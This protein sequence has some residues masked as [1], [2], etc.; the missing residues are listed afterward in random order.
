MPMPA[1][2]Y[3]DYIRVYEWNG[4]GEVHLGP[5]VAQAGSFGIYTDE[6]STNGGLEA[7]VTS[8]IYVWE[9]TLTAGSI[10]PYEGNN[11]LSWRTAGRGWFGA[12]VMSIQPLNLFDFGAG[13]L[14]F[15]IKIP[16]NV[17][18]KIGI[19]DAWGNQ[20]YIPFPAHQTT[21]GL[22]RDGEWGQGSIPV[23]DIRGTAMDLRMLS[24]PFVILEEQ[25]TPCEFA[26]DDIYWDA[27]PATGVGNGELA[28]GRRVELHPNVPNPFT[29][30]TEIRF[31][32]PGGGPYEIVIFDVAGRRLTGFRGVG[33]AGTNSVLWDGRDDAGRRVGSEIV[34]Y[35]LE[36][37]QHR[38]TR[39][40]TLVR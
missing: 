32:L 39:K 33:S 21:Y 11:V 24:Y 38:E 29:A 25:G 5:P 34:F 37:G 18:F 17:T 22:V 35:R 2:M 9:G 1:E 8:R 14:N 40:M 30:R 27:G 16:A 12:G 19:I 4:Q 3:V 10:P 13:H 7:E 23:A 36:A 20:S 28:A 31:D 15:R 26:V 6:T